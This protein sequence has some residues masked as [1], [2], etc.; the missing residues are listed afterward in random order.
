[1]GANP[2]SAVIGKA[3]E[4]FKIDA[5]NKNHSTSCKTPE[6]ENEFF[7]GRKAKRHKRIARARK[8]PLKAP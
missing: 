2:A 6:L 8:I 5:F 7:A 3:G 4:P 1:M